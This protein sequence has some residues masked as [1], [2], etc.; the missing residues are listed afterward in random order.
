MLDG[1]R[2]AVVVPAFNEERLVGPDESEWK[3][4]LG[5]RMR[6]LARQL[7]PGLARKGGES[8]TKFPELIQR[9]GPGTL[10]DRSNGRRTAGSTSATPE[11]AQ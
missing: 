7:L 2:V 11:Q 9:C 4:V 10:P 1:K 5:D 6:R 8:E 3:S